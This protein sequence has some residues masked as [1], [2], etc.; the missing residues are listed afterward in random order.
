[1]SW[2]TGPPVGLVRWKRSWLGNDHPHPPL[3]TGKTFW[4]PGGDLI[5]YQNRNNRDGI[6]ARF[7]VVMLGDPDKPMLTSVDEDE[8]AQ[9]QDRRAQRTS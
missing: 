3:R 2:C 5:H 6:R 9:R 8:L 4:E 1:V 7:L